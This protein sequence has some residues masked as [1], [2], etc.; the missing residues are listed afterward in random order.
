MDD[1]DFQARVMVEVCVAGRDDKF[2]VRVLDFS[3]LLGNAV[4]MMVVD[5]GDRTHDRRVWTC[6][7]FCN[8][9][10][11]DQITESLRP[12]S[13]AQSGNEIVKAFE[14]IRIECNSDSAKDAHG[15]S[16]EGN[17]L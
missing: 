9:P 5:E 13:V 7:A 15:H 1:Q 8:Q 12:V 17:C 6:C 2:V 16:W 10:I 14:K 4:G 11:A 3:Q